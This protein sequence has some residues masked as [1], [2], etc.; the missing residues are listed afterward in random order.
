MAAG[1]VEALRGRTVPFGAGVGLAV[2]VALA[3]V[4]QFEGRRAS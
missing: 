1:N 4:R 3:A 2:V